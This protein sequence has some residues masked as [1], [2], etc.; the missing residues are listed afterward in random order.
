MGGDIVDYS[1]ARPHPTLIAAHGNVGAMR[2]LSYEPGK[3]LTKDEI[4]ALHREGLGVGVVWETTADRANSGY[5]G[6]QHDA[7]VAN[8]QADALG[9]PLTLPI[10]YAVDFDPPNMAR[11]TD[12]F[13]G[14]LDASP[15]RAVG[16]YGSY[17]VVET[18]A[19]INC[20]G[21]VVRC[22][23]QTAGWS[24]SGSGSGGSYRCA[25]GSVRRL[26]KRACMFQDVGEGPVPG[27][28]RNAVL[29]PTLDWLWHPAGAFADLWETLMGE[30]VG[31]DGLGGLWEIC[32]DGYGRRRRCHIESPDMQRALVKAGDLRGNPDGSP[33]PNV[34]LTGAEAEAFISIPE[35]NPEWTADWGA[36]AIA[37]NVIEYVK[38][39]TQAVLV[40]A[41]ST[42]PAPPYGITGGAYGPPPGTYDDIPDEGPDEGPDDGEAPVD[43]GE[44]PD[45]DHSDAGTTVFGDDDIE[46]FDVD[47]IIDDDEPAADERE[48]DRDTGDKH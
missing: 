32:Y 39:C 1:W 6:G 44:L 5:T 28:D 25:D 37:A 36:V 43:Y 19:G 18:V 13:R 8:A 46:L 24:G 10:F 23:W 15:P 9:L 21:R 41:G 34:H 40:A 33:A 7:G 4:A 38:Q 47:E 29:D 27:T 26:S 12:Y 11:I 30:A 35:S 48:P 2:Y 20:A 45:P 22:Y 16:V 17:P 31:A 3:N 14:I 42:E